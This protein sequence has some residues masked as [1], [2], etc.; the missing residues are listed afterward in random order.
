MTNTNVE[1]ERAFLASKDL[2]EGAKLCLAH[3]PKEAIQ[4]RIKQEEFKW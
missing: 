2:H 1:S 3:A 4:L